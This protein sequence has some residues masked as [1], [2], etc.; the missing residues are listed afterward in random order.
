MRRACRAVRCACRLFRLSVEVSAIPSSRA[1]SRLAL[2]CRLCRADAR[3]SCRAVA[4]RSAHSR[5]QDRMRARTCPLSLT[6]ERTQTGANESRAPPVEPVTCRLAVPTLGYPVACRLAVPTAQTGTPHTPCA[7]P[8]EPCAVPVACAACPRSARLSCRACRRRFEPS[9]V[10]AHTRT[11]TR[12]RR[13]S[14]GYA[15]RSQERRLTGSRA[16]TGATCREPVEPCRLTGAIS[17]S[18]ACRADRIE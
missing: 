13:R 6:G 16:Q 7:V 12:S 15:V 5:S 2:A 14:L 8:V 10:A 3:L 18:R 17:I 4:V 9:P 11:G 1:R